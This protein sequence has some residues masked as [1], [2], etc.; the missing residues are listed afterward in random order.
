MSVK[1]RLVC[2][3]DLVA[4][5]LALDGILYAVAIL[6]TPSAASCYLRLV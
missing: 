1:S 5:L 4:M 3:V 6:L 2:S